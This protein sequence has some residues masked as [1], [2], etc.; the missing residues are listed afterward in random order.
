MFICS[1]VV[2][3]ESPVELLEFTYMTKIDIS[4]ADKGIANQPG[5]SEAMVTFYYC[6]LVFQHL[7]CFMITNLKFRLYI[8]FVLEV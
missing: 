7:R 5:R 3:P 2:Y 6:Q 1:V 4:L 8:P